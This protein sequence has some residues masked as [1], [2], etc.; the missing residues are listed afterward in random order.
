MWWMPPV[1]AAA[2]A[3][4]A[5]FARSTAM[6]TMSE[7][8]LPTLLALVAVVVVDRLLPASKASDATVRN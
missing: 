4:G 2:T 7:P 3:A 6:A 5:Y 8:I 1:L